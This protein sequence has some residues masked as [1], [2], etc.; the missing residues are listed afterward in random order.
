MDRD[1]YRLERKIRRLSDTELE[2]L[3]KGSRTP[4]SAAPQDVEDSVEDI[5]QG[6]GMHP[7]WKP[8]RQAY[9]CTY[10]RK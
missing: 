6:V 10:S 4:G 1:V 8:P 2:D 5:A 9:W 7:A 3:M